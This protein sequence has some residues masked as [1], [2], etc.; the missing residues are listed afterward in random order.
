L[1]GPQSVILYGLAEPE[2]AEQEATALAVAEAKDKASRIAKTLEKRLGNV[3]HIS[4][5]VFHSPEDF[6][7]RRQTPLLSRGTYLSVSAEQVEVPMKVTVGFEL[8]D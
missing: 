1:G 3:K 7:R 5:M 4:A 2:E 8:L 6:T